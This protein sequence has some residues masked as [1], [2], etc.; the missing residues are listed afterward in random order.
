M[1]QFPVVLYL[2]RQLDHHINNPLSTGSKVKSLWYANPT[3]TSGDTFREQMPQSC[4]LHIKPTQL[5]LCFKHLWQLFSGIISV[6]C[7][8]HIWNTQ[9][10]EFIKHLI[11]L[12]AQR[13]YIYINFP[14]LYRMWCT[15]LENVYWN[16]VVQV[17]RLPYQ[18]LYKKKKKKKN[19]GG[20]IASG[21]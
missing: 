7:N 15:A 1:I 3:Q 5:L 8:G 14:F 19:G 11:S 18:G 13:C 21:I 12:L 2:H 16:N 6:F 20:G 4:L 10:P 17:L 9:Q